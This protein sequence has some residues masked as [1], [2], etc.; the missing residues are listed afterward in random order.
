MVNERRRLIV[1]WSIVLGVGIAHRAML[2]LLHRGDLDALTEANAGWYPFQ[3]LPREMLRDHLARALLLLQQT[4]PVPNI[5][6][7]LALDGFSWPAGVTRV[8]IGL[9]SLV[10]LLAAAATR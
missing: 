9:Q 2:F 1:A 3:Y 6:M 10:S 7:G 4:P 5:L 8:L